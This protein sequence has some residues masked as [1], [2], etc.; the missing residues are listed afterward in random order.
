LVVDNYA[1][2]HNHIAAFFI[3]EAVVRASKLVVL[4]VVFVV[5]I[6]LDIL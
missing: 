6:V 1:G 3:S 5:L 2:V 4:S